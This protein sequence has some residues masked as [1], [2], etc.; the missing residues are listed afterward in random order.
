LQR[1]C[2]RKDL[3]MNHDKGAKPHQTRTLDCAVKF[4]G[5]L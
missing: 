2:T 1:I 4:L 3:V 5:Q